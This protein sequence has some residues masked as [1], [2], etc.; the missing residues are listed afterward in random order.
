MSKKD[1]ARHVIFYELVGFG[2]LYGFLWLDEILDL[3]RRI[4]GAPGTPI[5]W[6]ES[7][8][9][10]SLALV[11]AAAVVVLTRAF[12]KRIKYLEGFLIFCA[13][14]KRVCSG[15]RWVPVDVFVRDHADVTITHGLC[16]DCIQHYCGGWDEP[17]ARHSTEA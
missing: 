16:P 14:C 12:L 1:V 9:E 7:L 17:H 13:G 3:P 15:G 11:L 4:L 5:N 10:S 8:F 2:L 6:R